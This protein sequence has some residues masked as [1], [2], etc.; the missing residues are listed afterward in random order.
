MQTPLIGLRQELPLPDPTAGAAAALLGSVY[1]QCPGTDFAPSVGLA[2]YHLDGPDNVFLCYTDAPPSWVLSDGS[3]IPRRKS[4]IGVK[5]DEATR[6]LT[7]T[8]LWLP[9]Q[10]AGSE[11][12]DITM[13]FSPDYLCVDSGVVCVFDRAT[14]TIPRQLDHFNPVLGRQKYHR[15][16]FAGY[17]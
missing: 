12:W 2:S 11:K 13:T 1:C 17:C 6:T 15:L 10:F 9:H 14:D 5:L 4:L 16:M 3:P 8:V 7:G